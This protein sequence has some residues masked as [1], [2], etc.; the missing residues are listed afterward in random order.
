MATVTELQNR[1]DHLE[2]LLRERDRKR[3]EEQAAALAAQQATDAAKDAEARA[4]AAAAEREQIRRGAWLSHLLGQSATDAPVDF[5]AMGQQVPATGW[6]PGA[7]ESNYV[8]TGGTLPKEPDVANTA[9]GR[10]LA[11]LTKTI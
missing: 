10:T 5:A 9:L 7:D 11:S 4:M 1:V 3:V 2:A 8:F 6:P